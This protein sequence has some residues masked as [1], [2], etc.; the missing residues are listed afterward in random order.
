MFRTYIVRMCFIILFS[1]GLL[2]VSAAEAPQIS[3][4][5][6]VVIDLDSDET[7]FEKNADK[8]EYPASLTK[9]MT[10]LLTIEKGNL[11]RT[12]EISKTAACEEYTSLSGGEWMSVESL[13]T[14]MLLESDNGAA[15]A[16]GEYVSGSL[17]AFVSAMNEKAKEL[18]L[19][20]THFAN[21]NVLPSPDHYSTANDLAHIAKEALH[22]K[23]FRQLVSAKQKQVRFIR[24]QSTI[25]AVNTNKLLFTY[26]GAKG[27]KTGWTQSAGGCL[28]ALAEREGHTLLVIVLHSDTPATRFTEAAALLD[29]GFALLKEKE[30]QTVMSA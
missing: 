10:A 26:P 4:D 20:G 19:A 8:K 5:A 25:L 28:A 1:F 22:Q 12:V 30:I 21:A 2:Q 14:L 9:M 6:A 27:I 7:L 17:P 29:Y 16:A 24:P 3:A 13:L 18:S 15:T 11:W 23:P